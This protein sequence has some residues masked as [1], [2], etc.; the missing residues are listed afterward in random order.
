MSLIP[1]NILSYNKSLNNYWYQ[2]IKIPFIYNMFPFHHERNQ[3]LL[4]F[5]VIFDLKWLKRLN[6][7]NFNVLSFF[8]LGFD[9]ILEI[10]N[11]NSI[12]CVTSNIWILF[13]Q[14]YLENPKF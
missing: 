14:F 13:L 6:N 7:Q 12:L 4:F 3:H 10:L 5:K 9:G 2:N 11:E 1:I 8:R